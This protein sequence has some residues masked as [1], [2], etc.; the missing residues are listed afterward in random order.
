MSWKGN[1]ERLTETNNNYRKVLYTNKLQQLVIMN[2]PP[3]AEI[4][5]ERH[6]DTSQFIRVEKGHG[7]C[8]ISGK[9]YI[10]KEGDAVVIDPKAYH[11][12]INT[13][14]KQTLKLYTIYS[15]PVHKKG[16]TQ[17]SK[18]EEI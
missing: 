10:L 18:G 13:D 11:N 9:K 7:I 2:I 15:L 6:V 17:K 4:G 3:L 8:I 14:K 12:I 5:M 16:L 1:I